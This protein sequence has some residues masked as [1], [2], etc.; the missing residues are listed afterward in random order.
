[1]IPKRGNALKIA[2]PVKS[3]VVV[4]DTATITANKGVKYLLII[5]KTLPES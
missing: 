4:I 3:M 5:I 2:Y 1:M